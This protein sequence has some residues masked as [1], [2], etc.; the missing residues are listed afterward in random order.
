MHVLGLPVLPSADSRPVSHSDAE[1]MSN[2]PNKIS[3]TDTPSVC[4][5]PATSLFDLYWVEHLVRLIDTVGEMRANHD[6]SGVE[7]GCHASV[8][9]STPDSPNAL[10]EIDAGTEP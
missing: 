1:R 5:Q 3:D 7:S 6:S 9:P 2:K 4:P 10:G 8:S